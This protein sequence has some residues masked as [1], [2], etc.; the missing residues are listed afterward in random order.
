MLPTQ[1]EPGTVVTLSGEHLQDIARLAFGGRVLSPGVDYQAD[2]G[3]A[4]IKVTV[5]DGPEPAGAFEV[6]TGSGGKA[7]IGFTIAYPQPKVDTVTVSS[8]GKHLTLAGTSLGSAL[9]ARFAAGVNLTVPLS[10]SSPTSLVVPIPAGADPGFVTLKTRGGTTRFKYVP[11]GLAGPALHGLNKLSG[12]P[13][14]EVRLEGTGLF[15]ITEVLANGT[16][17]APEG[18]SAGPGGGWITVKVPAGL[19]KVQFT[20]QQEAQAYPCPGLF[21]VEYP[22]LITG[23]DLVTAKPGEKVVLAGTHLQNPSQ[24]AFGTTVLAPGGYAVD[25]AGTRLEITVP[26]GPEPDGVF[27]VTT[28]CGGPVSSAPFKISYPKPVFNLPVTLGPSGITV[29]GKYLGSVLKAKFNGAPPVTVAV[30]PTATDSLVLPIPA[31][32]LPGRVEVT[33]RGGTAAFPWVP[34][35]TITRINPTTAVGGARVAIEGTGLF[36]LQNPL[37]KVGGI[38]LDERHLEYQATPDGTRLYFYVPAEAASGQPVTVVT[39]GG[40]VDSTDL[41]NIDYQAP[42]LS[43]LSPGQGVAGTEVRL[44]GQHLGGISKVEFGVTVLPKGTWEVRKDTISSTELDVLVAQVPMEAAAGDAVF[45]VH[46]PAGHSAHSGNFNVRELASRGSLLGQALEPDREGSPE[47]PRFDYPSTSRTRQYGQRWPKAPIFHGYNP[48]EYSDFRPAL[49]PSKLKKGD[50]EIRHPTRVPLHLRLPTRLF[51]DLLPA[52]MTNQLAALPA[53]DPLEIH[54]VVQD[55]PYLVPEFRPQYWLFPDTPLLGV[56]SAARESGMGLFDPNG[57]STPVQIHELISSGGTWLT[58][59]TSSCSVHPD[60]TGT[61]PLPMISSSDTFHVSNLD[62]SVSTAFGSLVRD[63]QS[64]DRPN[65]IVAT[66][67]IVMKD[68]EILALERIL[69]KHRPKSYG[70]L[71][72]CMRKD[73]VLKGTVATGTLMAMVVP[74]ITGAAFGPLNPVTGAHT[75]TLTGSGFLNASKAWVD[76]QPCTVVTVASDTQMR[77]EV[78]VLGAGPTHTYKVLVPPFLKGQ[79]TH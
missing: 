46:N 12:P 30:K 37:V 55:Q 72:W 34:G 40:T 18:F 31:G 24:I 53:A 8:D 75:V 67:H 48:S 51:R 56:H 10:G 17:L 25:A 9:E 61:V 13:G 60:G 59:A 47:F 77:V 23:L 20:L 76:G 70:H 21:T 64:P 73:P 6:T 78:P 39:L 7:S 68:E 58:G 42:V 63:S 79:A 71:L 52:D 32:A 27:T 44:E 45:T 33:N 57:G 62:G 1:A 3:G 50:P 5:P 36:Q 22:P 2:P 29:T 65:R 28:P 11:A 66:V 74:H 49:D 19:D 14:C 26:D 16:A 38:W 69:R 41:F 4:W 35:P 15:F 43:T 54:V